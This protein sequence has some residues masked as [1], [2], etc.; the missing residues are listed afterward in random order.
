MLSRQKENGDLETGLAG[1]KRVRAN[2]RPKNRGREW[3]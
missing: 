2:P 3:K 1:G